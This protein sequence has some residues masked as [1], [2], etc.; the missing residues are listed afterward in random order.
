MIELF[1]LFFVIQGDTPGEW[2]Q[3]CHDQFDPHSDYIPSDTFVDPNDQE[4]KDWLYC[5]FTTTLELDKHDL[6][7]LRRDFN[8]YNYVN[9]TAHEF[10]N[11]SQFYQ[12]DGISNIVIEPEVSGRESLPP[13][14]SVVISYV[15]THTGLGISKY[16]KIYNVNPRCNPEVFDTVCNADMPNATSRDTQYDI[17]NAFYKLTFELSTNPDFKKLVDTKLVGFGPRPDG[18]FINV[19]PKY[20]DTYQLFRYQDT[21]REIVGPDVPILFESHIE[22]YCPTTE[23]VVDGKCRPANYVNPLYWISLIILIPVTVIIIFYWRKRK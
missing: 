14:M 11:D 1:L 12:S 22:I 15:Q 21:I 20:L 16:Y 6:E 10:V 8:W 2:L 4:F 9:Q 13:P 18:I 23:I 17:D 5:R 19:N 3:S 7:K